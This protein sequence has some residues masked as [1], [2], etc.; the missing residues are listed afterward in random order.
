MPA[1]IADVPQRLGLI[2]P[3]ADEDEIRPTCINLVSRIDSQGSFVV[4]GA[5]IDR[6]KVGIANFQPAGFLT[7]HGHGRSS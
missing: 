1:D 7:G 4:E 5:R 6:L 2:V 3:V